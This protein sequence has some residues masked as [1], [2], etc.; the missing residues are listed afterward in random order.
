MLI[1]HTQKF[2]FSGVSS[3]GLEVCG[4]SRR[5][6]GLEE[7]GIDFPSRVGRRI[8]FLKLKYLKIPSGEVGTVL[9]TEC[10]INIGCLCG[11]WG[12]TPHYKLVWMYTKDY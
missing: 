2:F 3:N 9:N 8:I 6:S 7:T 1:S 10:Q 4:V 11:F 12:C 5:E